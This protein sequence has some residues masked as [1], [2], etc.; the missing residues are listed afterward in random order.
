MSEAGD[1]TMTPE[2]WAQ[3]QHLFDELVDLAPAART[4]RLAQIRKHDADLCRRV[5]SLL[6]A[7]AQADS[8]LQ[9]LDAPE[10]PFVSSGPDPLQLIGERLAQYTIVA[11]LGGGG[12]GVVYKAQ[13]TR[14]ERM[15][16][17]KFLPPALTR[18]AEAKA[19]FIHEARSASALDHPNICTI[20]EINEHAAGHLFI[21]MALIEGETLKQKLARHPLPLA[22]AINWAEQVAQGLGQAHA[23]GIVHRDIKPANVMVDDAGQVKIVD[24]GLAKVAEVSLTETGVTLGTMAYMSPEQ[25]RGGAVDHRT[26][27]WALGVLLYEMVTGQRPFDGTRNEGIAQAILYAEPE[28]MTALRSRVPMALEQIVEKAL[29]KDPAERYQHVDE[30]P[31][32]LRALSSGSRRTAALPAGSASA[33][34]RHGRWKR[35]LIGA[36]VGVVIVAAAVAGWYAAQSTRWTPPA[37]VRFAV[38]LPPGQRLS[39][40]YQPLALS[41]DGTQLVYSVQAGDTTRLY[42]RAL[43][44]LETVALPGTEGGQDPF[45]SPDGRWIGFF[46]EGKLKKMQVTGG[47][48][49]PICDALQGSLGASWGPDDTI[50]MSLGV[51]SGLLRVPAAG[52]TPEALTTP[53]TEA[54]EVGHYW[55]QHLPGGG[56]LFTLWSGSGWRMAILPPGQPTWHVL[57]EEGAAARYLPTGHLVY[58][59]MS[60]ALA[61]PAL[62]VMP[63]DVDRQT[64]TGGPVSVLAYPGLSGPN[65]AVS[66]TGTLVYVAS[67]SEWVAFKENTLVWVD[68]TG[69]TT[70]FLDRGHFLGPRFSPDGSRLAV[71]DFSKTGSFDLWVYDV[72][73]GTRIRLTSQ[74][75][76]NNFPAWTPDNKRIAFTSTRVPPGLYWKRVDG[77]EEAERLLPRKQHIQIPGSWSPDGSALAF[78]RNTLGANSDLWIYTRDAVEPVPLLA[79][80]ANETAPRF[81]P[82]G[83]YIAYVSDASGEDAVYMRSYPV[84]NTT[85]P[86]SN[87]GGREPVWAPD[88]RRLFYRKGNAVMAV[89]IRTEPRF[90]AGTPVLLFEGNYEIGE[91]DQPNYDVAPDGRFLMMQAGEAATPTVFHVVLNWFTEL[92]TLVPGDQ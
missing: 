34:D 63:F 19:R 74:G 72:E 91:F 65:F 88:G 54:G 46:A 67:G 31:V 20:Y 25:V 48:P 85:W 49:Q 39:T 76:I 32:D 2:R 68:R 62:L 40:W 30:L 8:V 24:F 44:R 61:T 16:A 12:M 5:A 92:E 37:P 11:Y 56:V 55:P 33:M 17:L 69:H 50:I 7:H 41:P 82:D 36:L 53:N 9:P 77:N 83:Q 45:F 59:Q 79:T 87:G 75:T 80:P 26:D 89:S 10:I 28:P 23:R 14:L 15:V 3:L 22:E 51:T 86:I 78:T 6:A 64:A 21:A 38:T 4:R 90:S 1:T 52:G 29:A 58:A 71:G 70:P 66:S 47:I 27:I 81:S 60:R 35:T 18:D 73:H 13:D 43:D 57:P 84:P 42:R